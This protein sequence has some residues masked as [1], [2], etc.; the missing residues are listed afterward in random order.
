MAVPKLKIR[1][2]DTVEVT[3]GKDLGRRGTVLEV[4]PSER[5]VVVEQI[6]IAKRHSKPRPVKGTRGAQVTPGGVLDIAAPM[7]VDNLALVCPSCNKPTRVGYR[8][9][10]DGTK[11]RVCRNAGCGKDIRS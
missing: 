5:R 2:G 1:K 6:N 9:E 3:S 10:D 7:R 11:V 4:H 8:F